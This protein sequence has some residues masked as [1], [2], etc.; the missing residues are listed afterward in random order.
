MRLPLRND[1]G[2]QR[3]AAARGPLGFCSRSEPAVVRGQTRGVEA[4]G[5]HHEQASTRSDAGDRIG[6]GAAAGGLVC[7]GGCRGEGP[8]GGD[9]NYLDPLGAL[10]FSTTV[11]KGASS[12]VQTSLQPGNYVALDANGSH[13]GIHAL[14]TVTQAAHPASLP[15]PQATVASIEFGFRGPGTLHDGE[16]VR[17]EN[18]GFL[19]HM[20]VGIGVKNAKTAAKVTSLLKAGKDNQAGNLGTS[21]P[22]FDMGLSSGQMQQEVITDPPGIYVLACFMN[23]QDG[24]EHTQLGME[25]TI[26][27]V[28]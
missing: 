5:S 13:K 3:A 19:V 12:S 14:F 26:R 16:L 6:N 24:R 1:S 23:T 7:P 10:V 21:F 22:T 4:S 8:G 27:I 28:K 18:R 15:A 2:S 11:N 25:R 17:F 9:F 20:I